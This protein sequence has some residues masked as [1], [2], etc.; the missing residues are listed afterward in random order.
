MTGL[1]R[2]RGTWTV[3]TIGGRRACRPRR[4]RG[5]PVVARGRPPRGRG[6]PD[7]PAAAPLRRYGSD[8]RDRGTH[9]ASCPSSAIPTTPSTPARREVGLLVGPFERNPKTWAL[10]GIPDD[11]HARLL[12]ADLE[13]IEDCLVAAAGRIPVFGDV[14]LQT[15]VN[16][17]DGY[18]PDGKCLMGPI[19]GQPGLARPRRLLD[20][21]HRLRRLGGPLRGGVDRRWAAERQHV[22]ARRPPLR[23]VRDL[24]RLRRRPRLGGVRGTST[25]STTRRRNVPRAAR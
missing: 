9:D 11:F 1:E 4:H 25:R 10:D 15:V 13:Q 7:R 8:R 23:R 17:P 21:R 22:G 14:G 16:G 20:L 3:T 19:P 18:T 12:P 5:R 2:E 24:D 6:P